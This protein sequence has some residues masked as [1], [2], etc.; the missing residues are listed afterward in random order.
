MDP[1]R[2]ERLRSPERLTYFDPAYLWGVVEHL[3]PPPVVRTAVDI[4]TGVGY[5]ALPLA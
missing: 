5:L 3:D 4:G 2:I 1:A